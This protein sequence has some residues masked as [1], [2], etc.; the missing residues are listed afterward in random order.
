MENNNESLTFEEFLKKENLHTLF[1]ILPSPMKK[2]IEKR[3][4]ELIKENK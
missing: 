2:D 1:K 3:Y 4:Y